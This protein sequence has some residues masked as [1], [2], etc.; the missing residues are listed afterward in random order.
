MWDGRT[1]GQSRWL[2]VM[3]DVTRKKG[4]FL[5]HLDLSCRT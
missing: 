2:L 5:L 4:L 3:P 1:L